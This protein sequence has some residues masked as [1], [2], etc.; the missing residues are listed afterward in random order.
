VVTIV[1]HWPSA[2]S[3]IWAAVPFKGPVGSKRRLAG[4]LDPEERKRLSLV[5]FENV[6]SAMLHVDAIKQILVVTTGNFWTDFENGRVVTVE[7]RPSPGGDGESNG[8]LNEA[9]AAAQRFATKQGADQL[10]V[11]PAD[12]PLLGPWD[13]EEMIEAG[14]GAQVVIAPNRERLGT[15]GLLLSPPHAIETGFGERSCDYHRQAATIAGLPARII[16]RA[17][18]MLDL[19]TPEDVDILLEIGG[20]FRTVR[21]LHELGVPGRLGRGDCGQARST[22]I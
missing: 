13:L 1:G 22:T 11:V 9:V 10:A 21:L 19:D 3:G 6:L 4:L 14:R 5:M 20:D 12:L 8:G 2:G 17:G 7:V 16:E 18:F 15:N